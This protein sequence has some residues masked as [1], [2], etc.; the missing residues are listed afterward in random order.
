MS[1]VCPTSIQSRSLWL[2]EV[3]NWMDENYISNNFVMVLL[4]L[5]MQN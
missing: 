5:K 3:D 1:F 4:N 2:G